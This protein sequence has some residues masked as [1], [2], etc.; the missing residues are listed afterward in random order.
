[1]ETTPA[2]AVGA[3]ADAAFYHHEAM[4]ALAAGNVPWGLYFLDAA[5]FYAEATSGQ[6]LERVRMLAAAMGVRQ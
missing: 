4:T 2:P 1:M 5:D 6:H 3:L